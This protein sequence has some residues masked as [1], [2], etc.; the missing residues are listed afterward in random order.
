MVHN[1]NSFL[2]TGDISKTVEKKLVE[3]QI[4]INSD[5][6]KVAHHG[7][8]TSTSEEFLEKVLPEIA[9]V[10][11]GENKYG[12]PNTEVLERLK[13][14]AIKILRTDKDGDIKI[15]SD[16]TKFRYE[17]AISNF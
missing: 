4:N 9:I 8:K 2:F 16:G 10:Q 14:F 17:T 11:V 3:K 12:H 15:I 1:Q 6:L 5:I 7:S 13:F